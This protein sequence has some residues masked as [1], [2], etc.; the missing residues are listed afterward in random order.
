MTPNDTVDPNSGEGSLQR[1]DGPP[2][3]DTDNN[4][5][6]IIKQ[7]PFTDYVRISNLI[8]NIFISDVDPDLVVSA[9]IW[10]VDPDPEV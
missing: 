1:R 10:S 2:L 6:V 3:L 9:F 4:R 5:N 8:I 7:A